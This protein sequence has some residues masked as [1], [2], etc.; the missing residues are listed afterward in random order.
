MSDGLPETGFIRLSSILAPKGPTLVVAPLSVAGNWEE[1]V[2][3]FAP[4]LQVKVFGQ[5][6][7][8]TSVILPG[9]G[10]SVADVFDVDCPPDNPE[11]EDTGPRP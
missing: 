6:D 5:G 10:V 11:D 8:A 7:R 9:F 4:T 2:R 3:R 1:E